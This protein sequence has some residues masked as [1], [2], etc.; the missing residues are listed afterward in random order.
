MGIGGAWGRGYMREEVL[1]GDPEA[2]YRRSLDEA[3]QVGKRALQEGGT[4]LDAVEKVISML[5]NDSLFNAGKGS[6]FTHE[7][8]NELDASIMDGSTMNAGAVAAV[9]DIKNPIRFFL[10]FCNLN[11]LIYA[12]LSLQMCEMI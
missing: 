11:G 10:N 6:V 5:E 7:G 12:T 9:T 8:H 3:L 4:A 2:Q 1:T